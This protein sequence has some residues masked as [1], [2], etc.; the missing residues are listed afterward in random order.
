[1]AKSTG[2]AANSRVRSTNSG[3]NSNSFMSNNRRGS[4]PMNEGENTNNEVN[5]RTPLPSKSFSPPSGMRLGNSQVS[6]E[7]SY[8]TGVNQNASARK[9]AGN[10]AIS[11]QQRKNSP[12][13]YQTGV[14]PQT[15]ARQLRANAANKRYVNMSVPKNIINAFI[16]NI[17]SLEQNISREDSSKLKN[18][19]KGNV[20]AKNFRK[21]Q[22]NFQK[23]RNRGARLLKNKAMAERKAQA[24][25]NAK[26]AA[27][28]KRKAQAAENA[29]RAA[30]AKRKAQAAENAEAKR[31]AATK[32]QSTFRGRK[33][34]ALVK[35]MRTAA[36]TVSKVKSDVV[37]ANNFKKK[38]SV[39]ILKQILSNRGK[40]TN[41]GR[42]R[43]PYITALINMGLTKQ[44]L[45]NA[46]AS[47]TPGTA[48]ASKR[49]A[50]APASS[51]ASKRPR[52]AAASKRPAPAPASSPASKRLRTAAQGAS[53][54]LLKKQKLANEILGSSLIT[55]KQKQNLTMKLQSGNVNQVQKN[56]NN[57]SKPVVTTRNKISKARALVEL[58]KSKIT[59]R[60]KITKN[61]ETTIS[62]QITKYNISTGPMKTVSEITGDK[63][64]N[65]LLIMWLD[66]IHDKYIT[67]TFAQWL[68]HPNIH[69]TFP[70]EGYNGS[71]MFTF[72][73]NLRVNPITAHKAK[74]STTP[75]NNR[76]QLLKDGIKVTNNS[77][78][79]NT[80][81]NGYL[82]WIVGKEN[83]MLRNRPKSKATFTEPFINNLGFTPNSTFVPFQVGWEK[84]FKIFLV[85]KYAEKKNIIENVQRIK[86]KDDNNIFLLALDQEYST[87]Q[88]RPLTNMITKS[89]KSVQS[90]VTYGQAFDPGSTMLPEG[91][92]PDL[93]SITVSVLD[94]ENQKLKTQNATF[95]PA[96]W[97]YLEDYEFTMKVGNT[98]VV[99]IKF[100][101]HTSVL[102]LNGEPM[103]LTV[104]AGKAGKSNDPL[105]QLGKYFG[106]GLQYFIASALT[107]HSNPVPIQLEKNAKKTAFHS[108]MGSGDGMALFG[109]DFVSTQLYKSRA[110][111]MVIDFSGQSN[112]VAYIVNFPSQFF[113]VEK[114]PIKQRNPIENT[115]DNNRSTQYAQTSNVGGIGNTG[116]TA[117]SKRPKAKNPK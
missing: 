90:L 45:K 39:T 8:Q 74:T 75:L 58:Y 28:A 14:T 96:P 13:S 36:A 112:P 44:E 47:K 37:S 5:Q 86:A 52:T 2:S 89:G 88:E 117:Q 40:E 103:S 42:G 56:F 10:A 1:M 115:Y 73:Q 61:M 26:R 32:I 116:T 82:K 55:N 104:T 81:L 83:V 71:P 87:R 94:P 77:E 105:F 50:P 99:V 27:S 114:V 35:T 111:N 19:L 15:M 49:P 63:F 80:V 22:E 98:N 54:Y 107:K 9:S 62:E 6:G 60:N 78:Q 3:S 102:Q 69:K 68:K 108:F 70:P 38:H 92:V 97:Y 33:N 23:A 12:S 93:K 4:G 34:R 29:K 51:P 18:R 17:N 20:K 46:A 57:L 72:L 84:N 110:P 59:V 64:L 41:L 21:I 65:L 100:D 91:I 48:A 76:L 101:P 113:T 66:G 31:D 11:R 85:E 79:L 7:T 25:E 16:K 30:S 106:D 67:M 43:Q 24:A 109:Y 53:A 95:S